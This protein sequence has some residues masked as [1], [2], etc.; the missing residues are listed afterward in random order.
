MRRGFRPDLIHAH[1]WFPGG[2]VGTWLRRRWGVPLVLTMHGSDVRL[3][4]SP[5]VGRLFRHVL[6]RCDAVTTVSSWLA[7][8]TRA[9]APATRPVVAPMP[10]KPDI[11]HPGG[12]RDRDTLLFVGKLNAQKGVEHLLQALARMRTRPSVEIVVGVGSAPEDVRGLARRLGVESQLRWL[13][14][15]PQ[16]ALADRYR[17]CTALVMPAMEEG[18]GLVAAEALLCET[19][20]VAFASGGLTDLIVDGRT[21]LLVPP[22]DAD[23]LAH[24]LDGLLAREDHGASLGV[25]GRQAM[26][27]RFGPE[28][29]A[30]R[31][32][33]IYRDAAT[34]HGA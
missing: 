23:A 31:Y 6:A 10:I 28:A 3:A 30:D 4:A 20:V 32:V 11:F 22:G 17:A 26:L 27:Q 14:L 1:W 5:M 8:Q 15:L 19:P 2:L 9:V 24:A 34:A 13:P 33:A 21:G 7:Q 12:V 29:V 18:L 16:A 25:A